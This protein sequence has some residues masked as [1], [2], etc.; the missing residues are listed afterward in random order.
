MDPKKK[1]MILVGKCYNG[2][3]RTIQLIEKYFP[4]ELK[5]NT[6]PPATM[7]IEPI[8]KMLSISFSFWYNNSSGLSYPLIIYTEPENLIINVNFKTRNISDPK[9][10]KYK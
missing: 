2:K 8:P 10:I 1:L 7:P 4:I 9:L 6:L 5:K 3:S